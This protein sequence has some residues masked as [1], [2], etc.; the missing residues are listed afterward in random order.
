MR[1]RFWRWVHDMLEAAWH[2]VYYHK[3]RPLEPESIPQNITLTSNGPVTVN[4]ETGEPTWNPTFGPDY[5]YQEKI[6]RT[7]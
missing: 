7:K 1:L 6:R 2:W 5:P 3:L 4:C